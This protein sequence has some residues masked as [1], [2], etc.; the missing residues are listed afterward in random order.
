MVE[1]EANQL[2]AAI[3]TLQ[4]LPKFKTEDGTTYATI[5][6]H[7]DL[8]MRSADFRSWYAAHLWQ[9]SKS[10]MPDWQF[11]NALD[12]VCGGNIPVQKLHIRVAGD[13]AEGIFIDNVGKSGGIIHV[14]KLGWQYAQSCPY[15]FKR[16]SGQLP[17]PEPETNGVLSSLY[18][19]P[20]RCDELEQ[21]L[22]A[23]WLLAA[24]CPFEKFPFPLLVLEGPAGSGKTTLLRIAR[25]LTDPIEDE[26]AGLPRDEYDLCLLVTR[27][28]IL[29]EPRQISL[30]LNVFDLPL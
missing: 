27:H 13:A 18:A 7:G 19:L 8:D 3:S 28:L 5:D 12:V 20:F 25:A 11:K 10:V 9:H 21:R 16:P 29:R 14:T 6:G 22:F 30:R 24:M 1:K 2:N 23:A 17:L 26:P 4:T 15:K